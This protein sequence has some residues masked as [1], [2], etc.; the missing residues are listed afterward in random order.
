MK[1]KNG[2]SSVG[3]YLKKRPDMNDNELDQKIKN[4]TDEDLVRVFLA[5]LNEDKNRAAYLFQYIKEV[6]NSSATMGREGYQ[7]I[8][9]FTLYARESAGVTEFK[10]RPARTGSE[11]VYQK[12]NLKRLFELVNDAWVQHGNEVFGGITEETRVDMSALNAWAK[13]V[14]DQEEKEPG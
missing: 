4:M 13:A 6:V 7:P 11:E 8:A 1:K 5:M 3:T 9:M 2:N 14:G 10:F 12:L